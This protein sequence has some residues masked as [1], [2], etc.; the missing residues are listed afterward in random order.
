MR[1]SRMTLAMTA[2]TVAALGV[3]V[4]A[5][6]SSSKSAADV[7]TTT[8]KPAPAPL[9]ITAGDYSYTGVPATLEA[10]IVSIKFVNKGTVD[11][12]MAFLKVTDNS[13]P[14]TVFKSLTTV[15]NG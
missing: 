14:Q 6:G 12:E 5:C 3:G 7:T 2:V 13:D 1:S 9:T 15:L 11:H 10:G 4:T 8:A